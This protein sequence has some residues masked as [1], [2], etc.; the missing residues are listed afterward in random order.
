MIEDNIKKFLVDGE[1][2]IL[3]DNIN[4]GK[5]VLTSKRLFICGRKGFLSKEFVLKKEV[6]IKDIANVHGD[7]GKAD[8]LGVVGNSWLVVTPKV[9]EEWRCMFFSASMHL[10]NDF[11]T[12]QMFS[13]SK[14][15]NWVN[16][17]HLELLKLLKQNAT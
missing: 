13:I 17:I 2:V 3:S 8:L 7:L 12:A 16:A 10:F 15:N 6:E 1:N 9:G 14:V 11:N 5:L 4:E